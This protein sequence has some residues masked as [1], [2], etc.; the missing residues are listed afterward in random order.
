MN[1][2][3]FNTKKVKNKDWWFLASRE[4]KMETDVIIMKNRWKTKKKV[5]KKKLFW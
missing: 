4:K 1:V 5:F 2:T 3:A